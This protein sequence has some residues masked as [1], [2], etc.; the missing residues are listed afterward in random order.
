MRWRRWLAA[1]LGG[2]EEEREQVKA[3]KPFLGSKN[4]ES[5]G[6]FREWGR[7]EHVKAVEDTLRVR[8]LIGKEGKSEMEPDGGPARDTRA[9][10][11]AEHLN[12]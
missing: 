11:A 10:R 9:S 3:Q 1:G 6:R 7:G 12:C 2:Q 8:P 4:L 5:M